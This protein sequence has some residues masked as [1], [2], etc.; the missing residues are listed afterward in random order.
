MTSVGVCRLCGASKTLRKSHIIP[1]FIY[2]PM[3][4]ERHRFFVLDRDKAWRA[5]RLQKG[6][7]ERMLCHGCEQ[8]LSGFERYAAEV[9]SGSSCAKLRQSHDHVW[10][11]GLDYCQFKLFLLSILWRASVTNHEFFKLVSLG[12]H[13]GKLKSMI[14]EKRPGPPEEYGC[15]VIFS[16]LKGEDITDTMFNPEP[17]RWAGRRFYKFFFAGAGW[18]FYC[19]SQP[20][21]AHLRRLFLQED[22]TFLG[23]KMDLQD[24]QD[25]SGAARA[26]ARRRGLI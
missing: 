21:T 4:D 26:I 3:Y 15:I 17:F 23:L 2:Q 5:K 18:C 8:L 7:A 10:I 22:G 6:L 14:I 9:M 13:E 25:F 20:P 19:D 24:A 1:E 12:P 16:R 11:S